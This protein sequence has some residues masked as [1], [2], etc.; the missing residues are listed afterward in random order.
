MASSHPRRPEA[1]DGARFHAW[2]SCL[3]VLGIPFLDVLRVLAA[4]L[5]LG[6]VHFTDNAEG[7]AEPNGEVEPIARSNFLQ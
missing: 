1:E 4:V 2:K 3:G 7:N 5:L 6:N